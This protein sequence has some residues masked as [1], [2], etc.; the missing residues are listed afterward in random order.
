MIEYSKA[1][2][3]LEKWSKHD[4]SNGFPKGM[5]DYPTNTAFVKAIHEEIQKEM[6]RIVLNILDAKQSRINGKA[7]LAKVIERYIHGTE[8]TSEEILSIMFAE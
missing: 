2:I 7:I 4:I 3:M 6:D 8:Y 5:P 1:K